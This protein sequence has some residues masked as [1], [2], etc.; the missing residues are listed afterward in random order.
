[1]QT[2]LSLLLNSDQFVLIMRWVVEPKLNSFTIHRSKLVF[3]LNRLFYSLYWFFSR[4]KYLTTACISLWNQK[5]HSPWILCIRTNWLVIQIDSSSNW[6][7]TIAVLFKSIFRHS[8]L[9]NISFSFHLA[10]WIPTPTPWSPTKSVG[11][12]TYLGMAPMK[13][14]LSLFLL[15]R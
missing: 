3:L 12:P 7:L 6:L 11:K 14:F 15:P 2:N 10:R 5:H 1:M 13:P 4:I 8:A 9:W